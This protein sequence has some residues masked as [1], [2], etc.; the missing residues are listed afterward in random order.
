MAVNN[1]Q[2]TALADKIRELSFVLA[3]IQLY[4]DTH[5]DCPVA[6]DY[7]YRTQT[8]LKKLTDEYESK[9]AP[10]T[11][12]GATATDRWS[13]IDMPWPWQRE[14]DYKQPRGDK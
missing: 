5:P 10:L 8:E 7:F 6:L 1:N 3:E 14:G 2:M 9:Y 12:M 11:A 13:W 4:L